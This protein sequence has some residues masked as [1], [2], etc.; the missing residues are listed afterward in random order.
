MGDVVRRMHA[1]S[2]LTTAVR[3]VDHRRW[4]RPAGRCSTFLRQHIPEPG[5]VPLCGN[6][7]GTD[8]RFLAAYLPELD[9]FFHYRSIDV[10]T[11]KEL[12]RRWYPE[13]Y[14]AA[15]SKASAHRALDDIRESVKELRYYRDTIFRSRPAPAAE[16]ARPT[17]RPSRGDPLG[18]PRPPGTAGLRPPGRGQRAPR[19]HHAR[20]RERRRPRVPLPG[21]RRARHGRRG[22]GRLPRRRARP[23]HRPHRAG[24][25]AALVGGV[26]RPGS[27]ASPSPCWRRSSPP[28]PTCG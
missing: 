2:G 16:A 3:G 20:L 10:S 15:P 22:A 11:V 17:R 8:R 4:R 6:S 26:A 19:E 21:D 25:R 28:G 18:V 24:V 23:G 5:T 12:C 14:A 27:A 9:D 7:I 13:A 1:P